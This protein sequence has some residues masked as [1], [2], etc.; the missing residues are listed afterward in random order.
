MKRE[1][2]ERGKGEWKDEKRMKEEAMKRGEENGKMRERE[3]GILIFSPGT[4]GLGFEAGGGL[5][6]FFFLANSACQGDRLVPASDDGAAVELGS[7]YMYQYLNK[8]MPHTSAP[9]I[10]T[11]T[12][13]ARNTII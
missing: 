2:R 7:S 12:H 4:W 10:K 6:C 13:H 11:K 8:L 5:G 9:P 1:E 3:R